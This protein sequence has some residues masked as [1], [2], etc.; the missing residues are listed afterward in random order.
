[1]SPSCFLAPELAKVIS[2]SVVRSFCQ[3]LIATFA[4]FVVS[5]R[6]L[7]DFVNSLVNARYN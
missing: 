1:M 3:R 5:L 4:E 2:D 7:P 6:N